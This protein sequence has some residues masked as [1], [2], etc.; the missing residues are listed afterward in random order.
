MREVFLLERM[1]RSTSAAK[2][3]DDDDSRAEA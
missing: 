3:G 1:A 2:L